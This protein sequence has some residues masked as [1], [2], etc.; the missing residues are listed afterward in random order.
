LITPVLAV[1]R[2]FSFSDT[3]DY[4][5]HRNVSCSLSNTMDSASK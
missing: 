1:K 4:P 5:R 2:R 3:D